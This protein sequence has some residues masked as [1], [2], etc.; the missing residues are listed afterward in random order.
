M[1][2]DFARAFRQHPYSQNRPQLGLRGKSSSDYREIYED[3]CRGEKCTFADH[4]R[5]LD[6]TV[7][8]DSLTERFVNAETDGLLLEN[9]YREKA[10]NEDQ[11]ILLSCCVHGFSLRSRN[12]GTIEILFLIRRLKLIR[13]FAGYRKSF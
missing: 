2:I 13:S 12:W 4:N 8:D 7:L 1:I 6:D 11:L 3:R 9:A 10:L 5:I